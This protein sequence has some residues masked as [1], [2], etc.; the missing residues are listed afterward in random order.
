VGV[1]ECVG[2]VGWDGLVGDAR[3]VC[4]CVVSIPG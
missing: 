2:G 1:G 4:V 3:C